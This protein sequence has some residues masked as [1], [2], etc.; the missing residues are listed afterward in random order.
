MRGEKSKRKKYV[1]S[2]E[3]LYLRIKIEFFKNKLNTFDKVTYP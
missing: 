1:D 2:S 3:V